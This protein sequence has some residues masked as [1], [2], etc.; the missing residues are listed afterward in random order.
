MKVTDSNADCYNVHTFSG[1]Y[2]AYSG[3]GFSWFSSV[4][5]SEFWESKSTRPQQSLSKFL[6][7]LLLSITVSFGAI[8]FF[9]KHSTVS[10][11]F[12]STCLTVYIVL[13]FLHYTRLS[14][15]HSP[16]T[17]RRTYFVNSTYRQHGSGDLVLIINDVITCRIWEVVTM[18]IHTFLPTIC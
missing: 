6:L 13:H 10:T 12:E 1:R 4:P 14:V 2:I 18:T 3:W 8:Y 7:I 11:G 17:R 5:D 15:L 16:N 9:D